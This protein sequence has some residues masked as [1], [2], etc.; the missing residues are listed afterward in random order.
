M[1]TGSANASV[2]FGMSVVFAGAAVNTSLLIKFPK[3]GEVII[4]ISRAGGLTD[5]LNNCSHWPVLV[6]G[7]QPGATEDA[8]GA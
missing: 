4:S 3:M 1:T 2:A 6:L 5:T 8:K 7:R